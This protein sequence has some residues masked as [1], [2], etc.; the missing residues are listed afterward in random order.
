MTDP[1]ITPIVGKVLAGV[2]GFIGG[3]TFMAFYRPRNVWDAAIRSSVS[4]T[5][6]IIGANP[7]LEYYNLPITSDNIICVGAIFGF[8]A[9]SILTLAARTLLKIQD[10]KTEIKL[11]EFMKTKE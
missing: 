2:G 7:F 3:A 6:A 9:W 1:I 10:E 4:T 8:C 5:A 11:P